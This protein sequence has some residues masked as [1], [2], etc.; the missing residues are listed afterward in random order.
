MKLQKIEEQIDSAIFE[1]NELSY[2]DKI[3]IEDLN[4]QI[5]KIYLKYAPKE[6]QIK[7]AHLKKSIKKLLDHPELDV[8]QYALLD[9]ALKDEFK[10]IKK[11]TMMT[12]LDDARVTAFLE[13]ID[14]IYI[15]NQPKHS[16]LISL[17][18]LFEEKERLLNLI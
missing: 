10:T 15:K 8:Q 18:K 6:K 5:K 12:S 3:K 7:I 16:D 1:K 11:P 2:L 9:Y 4:K 14:N 13:R 17:E